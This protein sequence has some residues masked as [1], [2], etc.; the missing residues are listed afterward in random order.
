[1]PSRRRVFHPQ[2]TYRF[3]MTPTLSDYPLLIGEILRRDDVRAVRRAKRRSFLFDLGRVL[4]MRVPR[5]VGIRK[6]A[7][8]A[9]P[10]WQLHS[11][12]QEPLR[13]SL[14]SNHSR[15]GTTR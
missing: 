6:N 9:E 5:T 15:N 7:V 3:S 4:G 12:E 2:E 10:S 11:R 8:L 14:S 13:I 1:M